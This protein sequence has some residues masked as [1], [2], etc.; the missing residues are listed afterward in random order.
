LVSKIALTNT[1]GVHITSE[2]YN[3]L[4]G[5]TGIGTSTPNAKLQVSG[6]ANISGAVVMSNTTSHI[7]AATFSNTITV[8]GT[9]TI[10][11]TVIGASIE[12]NNN[13]TGDR[14]ALVD[15]HSDGTYTD[16]SFRVLAAAG[17]NGFRLIVARVTTGLY[18]DTQDSAPI[19]F[20]TTLTEAA[21][22]S[23]SGNVG[24]GNTAPNAKL[25]VTGT[26]NISGDVVLSSNLTVTGN[27]GIGCTSPIATITISANAGA[28]SAV[29]NG[30]N[31]LLRVSGNTAVFSEP[32]IEFG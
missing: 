28:A 7:G 3:Y 30:G 23:A 9:G 8:T 13:G 21:R 10:G 25:H 20:R 15:L 2:N 4:S 18:L 19:V 1:Y 11:N 5:N 14:N 12:V 32:A 6:A 29:F 16:Y 31:T 27:V 26:A 24:I 22:I 17:N